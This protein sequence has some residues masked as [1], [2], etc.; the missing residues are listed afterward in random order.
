MTAPK[1]FIASSSEGL[2]VTKTVRGRLLDELT[3]R[4]E[5]A[6][7]QSPRSHVH[8]EIDMSANHPRIAGRAKFWKNELAQLLQ[9]APRRGQ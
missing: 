9:T 5:V 3:D 1:V 7:D 6:G 4:A 8:E 2:D